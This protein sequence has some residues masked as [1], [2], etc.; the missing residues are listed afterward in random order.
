[1]YVVARRYVSVALS[2]R[3]PP[4]AVSQH[5]ALWSSDFPRTLAGPRL[6]VLLKPAFSRVPYP[7]KP[8]IPQSVLRK[9]EQK[10]VFCDLMGVADYFSASKKRKFYP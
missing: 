6:P 2:L 9:G 10:S 3:L 4:L 8:L 5:S 1:M 7:C